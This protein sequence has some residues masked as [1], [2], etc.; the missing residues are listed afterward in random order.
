MR[1]LWSSSLATKIFLSYLAVVVLLFACFYIYSSSALKKSQIGEIS[2]AMAREARFLARILPVNLTGPLLD[3]LCRQLAG[4]LELRIT[5]V[6]SDGKVLG[7]SAEPSVSMENHLGRPEVTDAVRHG[8]GSAT[9]YSTTVGH[10]MVYH[11]FYQPISESWRVIR[12]A[13]PL[14]D[15]ERAIQALRWSLLSGLL[16]ASILG[17]LLAWLFSRRLTRR[18]QH[19]AGFAERVAQGSFPRD[20]FPSSAPDEIAL[21]EQQLN[22]MSLKI[23]DN[24]RQVVAEKEKAD[25]ILRCMVEGVVVLDPK[26]DVMLMNERAKSMFGVPAG[27][28]KRGV[29]MLEISRH[30]EM[31]KLLTE[32]H[33]LELAHQPYGK[34][35]ELDGNRWFR[36][37]AVKLRDSLGQLL[38]SILVFHDVTEVKRFESM[39][40]DFVAN[41]SHELRTPLTAIRGYVETLLQAPPH[42]PQ[43]SRQFLEII[44]RHSERLSRLTEDLLILS[45]LESGKI[46]LAIQP[47][48]I[49][50][51]IQRVLEIF[52]D[53]AAKQGVALIES[54]EPALP[55]VSG[56]ADRLQQLLINLIDNAIKYTP[57]GGEVTIQ[58][59]RLVRPDQPSRVEVAV[60]DT[61]AGIPEHDLPRLTERFYRV[62]KARSR[63]LGGT[64]LGL[65]IV[66]HIVQAHKGELKIESAVGKGTTVRVRLS[67]ALAAN[68][69]STTAPLEREVLP[70]KTR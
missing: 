28:N 49:T 4:E 50:Q 47:L 13:K 2:S 31:R 33:R 25:S 45:D 34:E 55:K 35:L 30:P 26:G 3:T 9:R 14:A 23:Q 44:D 70:E 38:G 65:A 21:L 11:A 54:I 57:A 62:D 17:L 22:D 19:L 1:R 69:A 52:W 40:S 56:D 37:N 10:D 39:R 41:V 59:T 63:E 16:A 43:D 60:S 46:Q 12:V 42:N 36:L 53:R 27:E 64:G 68:G 67:E 29:S 6:G 48:E 18:F 8:S 24:L 51:L 15:V 32:L 66:K 5:V 20:F 58:A 7:D 61:G